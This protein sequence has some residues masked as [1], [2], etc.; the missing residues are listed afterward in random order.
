VTLGTLFAASAALAILAPPAAAQPGA[1]SILLSGGQ[2]IDAVGTT[3]LSAEVRWEARASGI[4]PAFMVGGLANGNTCADSL[5]PLCNY[6]DE[7]ALRA[8]GGFTAPFDLGFAQL[9]VGPAAGAMRW[10]GEWDATLRFDA[11]LRFGSEDGT[12]FE[13][14]L[15][16]DWVRISG[17]TT[18]VIVSERRADLLSLVVGVRFGSSRGDGP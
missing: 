3:V 11:A 5:P 8:L 1:F 17:R 14:G 15:R 7:G 9:A 13:V 16:Q 2:D 10:G 4:T 12:Q 18:G 6:P